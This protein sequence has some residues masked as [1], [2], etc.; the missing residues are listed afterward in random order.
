MRRFIKNFYF[1]TIITKG[2][3]FEDITAYF[4]YFLIKFHFIKFVIFYTLKIGSGGEMVDT[5][6]SKS[7]TY[8]VWRFE[9][10][11]EQYYEIYF[12]GKH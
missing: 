9:S 6:D 1:S 12:L 2:K 11:S 10:S 4:I 7:I 5:I 3:N 8:K